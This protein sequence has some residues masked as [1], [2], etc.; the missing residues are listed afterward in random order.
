MTATFCAKNTTGPPRPHFFDHDKRLAND[1]HAVKDYFPICSLRRA[2]KPIFTATL[3]TPAIT[4]VQLSR[5]TM[6]NAPN[7]CFVCPATSVLLIGGLV[8]PVTPKQK[9]RRILWKQ[10]KTV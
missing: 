9:A 7:T 8:K 6:Q 4:A 1:R 2:A 10:E 3:L 5:S